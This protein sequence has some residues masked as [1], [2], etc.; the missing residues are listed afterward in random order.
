MTPLFPLNFLKSVRENLSVRQSRKPS[1]ARNSW[2][3]AASVRLSSD[4]LISL[5]LAKARTTT[6][7]SA[8]TKSLIKTSETAHRTFKS[9]QVSH[10]YVLTYQLNDPPRY[11]HGLTLVTY[12]DGFDT[13]RA[14]EESCSLPN[15]YGLLQ[16]AKIADRLPSRDPGKG[17]G[18]ARPCSIERRHQDYYS[19]AEKMLATEALKSGDNDKLPV[20]ELRPFT[21]KQWR[22][23]KSVPDPD[24]DR[25]PFTSIRSALCSRSQPFESAGYPDPDRQVTITPRIHVGPCPRSVLGSPERRGQHPPLR[26]SK[27]VYVEIDPWRSSR[28]RLPDHPDGFVSKVQREKSTVEEVRSGNSVCTQF[29]CL[30]RAMTEGDTRRQQVM[31]V[32]GHRI[33]HQPRKANSLYGDIEDYYRLTKSCTAP[34]S[35]A[36]QSD[37][38]IPETERQRAEAADGI[39]VRMA[40]IQTA[41][42]D[43]SIYDAFDRSSTLPSIRVRKAPLR[44][45]TKNLPYPEDGDASRRS[46]GRRNHLPAYRLGVTNSL[47]LMSHIGKPVSV[48]Y[49]L[50]DELRTALSSLRRNKD[51]GS[52]ISGPYKIIPRYEMTST[53]GESR[54]TSGTQENQSRGFADSHQN[55]QSNRNPYMSRTSTRPRS[56]LL[57][58]GI[59]S[60]GGC[61]SPVKPLSR[62]L[63]A[64]RNPKMASPR[65]DKP[66]TANIPTDTKGYASSDT[67]GT[68]PQEQNMF[69]SQG[70]HNTPQDQSETP[71]EASKPEADRRNQLE[72]SP[73]ETSPTADGK[74]G[75]EM[76]QRGNVS[77]DVTEAVDRTMT[78]TEPPSGGNDLDASEPD[79]DVHVPLDIQDRTGD[80]VTNGADVATDEHPEHPEGNPD[81]S[82]SQSD[83]SADDDSSDRPNDVM[84]RG[85]EEINYD[86]PVASSLLPAYSVN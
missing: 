62:N 34:S 30:K 84:Y 17:R 33:D 80:V 2:T 50:S 61:Y 40:T 6:T 66:I 38:K 57:D 43:E 28:G 74:E 25:R 83:S 1:T 51:S 67:S 31:R 32:N 81:V 47:H 82:I 36:V 19:V 56:D 3:A 72:Q 23:S 70:Q 59:E 9:G 45:R 11:P 60:T 18:H 65:K 29:S 22:P 26:E 68:N 8:T 41:Y 15:P 21:K 54:M 69:Y 48:E 24:I 37:D 13:P 86:Q 79:V 78:T 64:R 4:T 49:K 5:F 35:E 85:D 27:D 73:E 58:S 75:E 71:S 20:V 7:S 55:S 46:S 16:R 39:R 53:R 42:L 44:T 14:K 77:R 10:D 63:D 52:I 76:G 12:S